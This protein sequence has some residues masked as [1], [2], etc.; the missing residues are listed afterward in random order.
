MG[1]DIGQKRVHHVRAPT[2]RL[3]LYMTPICS[4]DMATNTGNPMGGPQMP[5]PM[6]TRPDTETKPGP[7]SLVRLPVQRPM[8]LWA[9]APSCGPKCRGGRPNYPNPRGLWL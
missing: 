8:T 4:R 5:I 9:D 6:L 2:Q 3:S 7:D 1:T